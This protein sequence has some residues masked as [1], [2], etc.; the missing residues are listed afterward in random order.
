VH[1][2]PVAEQDGQLQTASWGDTRRTLSAL[3]SPEQIGRTAAR[4]AA[5][6]LGAR[7][8]KTQRVPVVFDPRMAAGFIGSLAG[9]VS[10]DLVW[11]KSSFLREK[12]GQRI[13]PESITIL[14]DATLAHGI[15]TRPFD[16]EG[17]ASRPLPIV[18]RG[19]LKTFLYDSRTARKAGTKPTGSASRGWSSLP[20]I[21]A[22]NFFL[23][24][25]PDDPEQIVKGIRNGLYVTAMLGRGAD[26]VTGDYSRGANGLWIEDGALAYPVQEI[27]VSGNLLE[28]LAAIDAVG[29]DL[30]FRSSV[31]APTIRFAE[32][33]VSGA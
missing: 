10:G 11:K 14:D 31:A 8:P 15:S 3:E 7:K 16:G 18:E 2:S 25:G 13:A 9:A 23:E 21:G 28:M 20:S 6:M 4:R 32:L 26:V 5:R 24:P 27:T 33:Q 12:L 22:S 19:V 17:V 29:T 1:C 30:D